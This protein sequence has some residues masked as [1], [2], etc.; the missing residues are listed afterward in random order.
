MYGNSSVLATAKYNIEEE[1]FRY[2]N[3]MCERCK[4]EAILFGSN[5]PLSLREIASLLHLTSQECSKY[6]RG[7][8]KDYSR[9][10]TSLE[11][12]K[13]GNRYRIELKKEFVQ[14]VYP[15]AEKE[16]SQSD[17]KALGLIFKSGGLS[18]TQMRENFGER[19]NEIIT[20]LKDRKLISAKKVGRAEVFRITSNFFKY[21]GVRPE[22]IPMGQEE[23]KE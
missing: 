3:I 21:F 16:F 23:S 9:R 5:T 22:D 19:Y 12:R 8:I 4:V 14:Y 13:I 1:K 6:L 11:I 20:K 7:L 17:L 10:E 2:S 15:V 18:R